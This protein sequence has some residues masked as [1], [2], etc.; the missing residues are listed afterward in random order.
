MDGRINIQPTD[1]WTDAWNDRRTDRQDYAVTHL[2]IGTGVDLVHG[3]SWRAASL[4]VQIVALHE[5]AVVAEAADPHVALA[6]V[7]QLHT[8]PDVKSVGKGMRTTIPSPI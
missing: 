3:I 8:L 1:G 2:D 7:V 6:P 4:A 5:D